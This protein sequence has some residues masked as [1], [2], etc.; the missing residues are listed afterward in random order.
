[1]DHSLFWAKAELGYN[2][3]PVPAFVNSADTFNRGQFV[4][5]NAV[6]GS[7]SY[8]GSASSVNNDFGFEGELGVLVNPNI[9]IGVGVRAITS[10]DYTADIHYDTGDSEQLTLNGSLTPITVDFYLFLPEPL[11]RFFISGGL[12]AYLA[13][14]KVVQTTTSKNFFGTDN[15]TNGGGS[16][17]WAGL[18]DSGNLGVQVAAGHDFAIN[19]QF[20]FEI[21]ARVYFV[22]ISNFQGALTDPSG[23]TRNYG[24]AESASG[25]TVVDADV[26]SHITGPEQYANLDFSG[27]DVGLTALYYHF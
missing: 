18:L 19:D 11:G 3:W 22:Q 5:G 2:H 12:G 27:F 14:V 25:P 16:N 24:L 6:S 9:G 21:Y 23:G 26:Q 15:G 4:P 13:Q 7:T 1:V 10:D 17:N 8:S 20:G